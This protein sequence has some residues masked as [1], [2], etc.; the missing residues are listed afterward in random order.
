MQIWIQPNHSN[1][2]A[3]DSNQICADRRFVH[4]LYDSLSGH[5]FLWSKLQIVLIQLIFVSWKE[6]V[7]KSRIEKKTFPVIQS[8]EITYIN[9]K[10]GL[11]FNYL[12]V[13]NFSKNDVIYKTLRLT[14]HGTK[15]K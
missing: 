1:Q 5:I 3:C 14:S 13:W 6:K 2:R 12:K 9:H 8:A 11:I 7:G 10:Y 15:Y 4:C